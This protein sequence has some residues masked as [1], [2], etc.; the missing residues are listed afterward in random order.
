MAPVEKEL[1]PVG[2]I[3]NLLDSDKKWKEAMVVAVNAGGTYNIHCHDGGDI[4]YLVDPTLVKSAGYKVPFPLP[5]CEVDPTDL[6][7]VLPV[8][9]KIEANYRSQGTFFLGRISHYHEE[10]QHGSYDVWFEDGRYERNCEELRLLSAAEGER[11]MEHLPLKTMPERKLEAGS[12]VTVLDSGNKQRCATVTSVSASG[13]YNVQCHDGVEV[14]DVEASR[15]KDDGYR[16]VFPLQTEN[17][18][19]KP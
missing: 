3:V 17:Q 16:I 12:I 19:R 5:T 6:P 11:K 9:C 8:G 7:A 10:R 14:C 18:Q 13:S 15:V 4:V 2:A 1:L